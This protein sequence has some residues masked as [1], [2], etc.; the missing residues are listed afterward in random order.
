M[1]LSGR[2][3]LIVALGIAVLVAFI[4]FGPSRADS[5]EHRTDSDAANGASALLQLGQALGHPAAILGASFEPD[6]GMGALFVLTP[7]VG[8]SRDEARRLSAYIAGGGTV[9]YAAEQGD[10]QL[11]FALKVNRV[12]SQVGGAATG[13][14]PALTGVGNVSGG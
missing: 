2:T 5:P 11:D 1:R 7:T 4:I 14:G 3:V 9:V 12:R 13:T 6:L 10:P 8:F